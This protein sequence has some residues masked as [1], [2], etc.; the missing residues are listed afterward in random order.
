MT[1]DGINIQDNYIRTNA[2]DYMPM[3]TTIDQISEM[4]INTANGGATHRRRRLA[5]SA[6]HAG[7][8]RTIFTAAFY[9]Y[10]RNSALAANDWFNNKS[11]VS[12]V[13]FST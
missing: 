8:A 5:D 3:R 10:N 6:L 11:G 1:L 12:R 9:W 2:L 13:P 4:T 7:R